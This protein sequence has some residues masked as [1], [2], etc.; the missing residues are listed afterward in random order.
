MARNRRIATIRSLI[1]SSSLGGIPCAQAL[2]AEA[3]E[4]QRS[5]KSR[6]R[7]RELLALL[8]TT[9]LLDT[10]LKELLSVHGIPI[11]NN[12]RSL[13]GYLR[14][15]EGHNQPG[16]GTLPHGR[17]QYFQLTV[18]DP[19]NQVMHEADHWP[20]VTQVNAVLSEMEACLSEA[21]SL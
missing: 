18:V 19:R 9:R 7:R 14:L 16:V 11:P 8:H 15:L 17:A 1:V 2:L 3:V 21:V 13:G 4:I 20:S 6:G 5:T 10:A 12:R